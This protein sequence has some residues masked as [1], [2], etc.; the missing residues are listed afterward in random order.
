MTQRPALH[1]IKALR[2]WRYTT[3]YLCVTTTITVGLLVVDQV[4]GSLVASAAESQ[5]EGNAMSVFAD[6]A[7]WA[8]IL[9]VL[10]PLIVSVVQQPQWSD[11]TRAVVSVVASVLIGVVTVLA[12]GGIESGQ[13][14]LS[15]C[16]L[17][18]VAS[19]TAY[20]TLWKPTGVSPAIER[21]TSKSDYT[22]AA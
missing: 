20:K 11:R 3:I 12:N 21:A 13:T 7:S 19:N 10:T 5:K 4:P 2:F 18:F 6:S 17:V 9:G 16:A 1:P 8:L 22:T 15:V 14:L